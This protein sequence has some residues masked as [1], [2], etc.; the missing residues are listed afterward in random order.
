LAQARQGPAQH[1]VQSPICIVPYGLMGHDQL[2]AKNNGS[3]PCTR[4]FPLFI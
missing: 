2:L 3:K 1:M 4:R